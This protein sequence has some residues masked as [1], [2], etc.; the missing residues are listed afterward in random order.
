MRVVDFSRASFGLPDST[1]LSKD[2]SWDLSPLLLVVSKLGFLTDDEIE[3]RQWPS[4][5]FRRR[6]HAVGHGPQWCA[7]QG[8][9]H[10]RQH[11]VP[12]CPGHFP[13]TGHHIR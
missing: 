9:Q 4:L 7:D 2:V 10:R 11:I 13:L 8:Q 12:A 6:D 5:T 1:T 3:A